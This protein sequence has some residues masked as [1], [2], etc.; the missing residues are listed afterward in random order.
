MCDTSARAAK[1][2]PGHVRKSVVLLVGWLA[3][4]ALAPAASGAVPRVVAV[5]GLSLDALDELATEG[6]V[7]LVVPDA[8]PST[9]E[10]RA[11]AS[12]ERGE[13]VNSL[14]G[15]PPSGRRLVD[16]TLMDEGWTAYGPRISVVV[17]G[18]P[19]GG[20][21]PNDRRYPIGR[22]G[23]T[24]LLTS[25]STRIPGIVSIAD[26]ATGRL[27]VVASGDPVTELRELDQRIRDNGRSRPIAGIVIAALIAA[28]A[29]VRPRAAVLG[30]ATAAATNLVLGVAGISEPWL[31]VALLALGTLAALP[32][33]PV[34]R[35]PVAL[36]AVLAGAIAAYLVAMA[37]DTSWVALSPL[38]PTQNARFYG[39]SNLLETLL[40]VPALGAAALLGRRFGWTA[41]AGTAL[42]CLVTVAGSRFGAD[43]GGAIVLAAGFAVVGVTLAGGGR[44]ATALALAGG[45]AALALIAA[46]ALAGPTTHVGESL[47]DGPD[48]LARDLWERLELSW[49]RTTDSAGVALAVLTALAL[50]AVLAARGARRPL[51]LAVLGAIAVSLLV[52]DSPKEVAVG[53]LVAY[54]A[55]E[56]FSRTGERGPAG[57][58]DSVIS[59]S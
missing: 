29:F 58:T 22:A 14:R 40:L 11:V 55:A 19:E 5:P 24:G 10:A 45:A 32:L 59:R 41:L 51:P 18:V 38:G 42:L 27:E 57:Y 39:L 15:D 25:E 20:P 47:R 16:V 13:V 21:Q 9:S 17:V 7:G 44:R 6:A 50:L 1:Q 26:V 30:F 54:L 37:A 36:G 34:L 48:E 43:G 35:S 31:V 49:E 23:R 52:N 33:A 28:L 53:G 3:F 8:G 56:R 46:D 2:S 4:L 12:L